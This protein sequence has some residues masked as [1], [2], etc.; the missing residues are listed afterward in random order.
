MTKE[1]DFKAKRAIL[2]HSTDL[3][4]KNKNRKNQKKKKPQNI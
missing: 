3:Y 2:Y 1:C 4:N